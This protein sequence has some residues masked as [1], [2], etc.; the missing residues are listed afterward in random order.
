MS[1]TQK[2]WIEKGYQTFAL[3][4]PQGLK[5]ERLA[6][7]I[8]K[9]KSSF[10]HHFADWEV[11]TNFLLEHHLQQAKVLAEKEHQATNQTE[12]VGILVEHKLDL[13]FNRQLR[14]HRENQV[15]ETVFTEVNQIS[16][17]ALMGIWTQVLSLENQPHLANLVFQLSIE[18][19]FLQITE[20]TLNPT[21]LN[22]YID[23]LKTMVQAFKNSGTIAY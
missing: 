14:I 10:Y 19:F 5:V 4:G 17:P 21:W 7:S 1:S 6:K 13:L 3:E 8:G 9:N 11:F 20:E 18:N 15:F 2:P 12:L 16:V 22:N 23:Q